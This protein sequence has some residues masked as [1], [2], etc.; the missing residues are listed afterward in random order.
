MEWIKL[1]DEKPSD[2]MCVMALSIHNKIYAC[3]HYDDQGFVPYAHLLSD[4]PIGVVTH[5]MPM[6]EPPTKQGI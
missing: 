3:N 4:T 2:Y 1:S 5:W 6:P